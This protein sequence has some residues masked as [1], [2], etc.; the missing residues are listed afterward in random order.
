[1]KGALKTLFKLLKSTLWK[2]IHTLNI[3]GK[4]TSPKTISAVGRINDQA[5]RASLA[6]K[7]SHL[8]RLESDCEAEAILRS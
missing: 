4:I 7:V 8:D 3:A 1:L 2:L 5:R 6:S